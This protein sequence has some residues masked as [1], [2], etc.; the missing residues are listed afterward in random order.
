MPDIREEQNESQQPLFWIYGVDRR[1]LV[2]GLLKDVSQSGCQ[3]TSR[4]PQDDATGKQGS[5]ER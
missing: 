4:G 1:S 3:M 5:C 2:S